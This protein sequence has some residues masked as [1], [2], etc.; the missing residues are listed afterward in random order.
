MALVA[1]GAAGIVASI[2]VGK[3]LGDYATALVLSH[4]PTVAPTAVEHT[5]GGDDALQRIADA[6]ARSVATITTTSID[7]RTS[8]S[9]ITEDDAVG[10][11]VVAAA[12]GWVLTT[13][14]V[15]KR[16]A[17]P[18]TQLEVWVEGTRYAVT[19][20][21]GDELTD[22][23]LMKIDASGLTP[24]AFGAS[25]TVQNGSTVYAVQ[26]TRGVTTT[27]VARVR[28]GADAVAL[29]AEAFA[30][31][32]SLAFT[33]T[34]SS[35]VFSSSGD[36]LALTETT[37]TLPLHTGDAFVRSVLHDGTE[38]IAGLGARVVDLSLPLNIDATLSQGK[39]DGALVMSFARTSPAQT[40]GVEV[41]DIITAVDD[42]RIDEAT[43]LAEVLRGYVPGDV[44]TLTLVRDGASQRIDVHFDDYMSLVY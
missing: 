42:V 7:A 15:V 14:D 10:Y 3:S 4:I 24:A 27:S 28:A 5:Q 23:V 26:G 1:G 18:R 9:W 13:N 8:T 19:Q 12:D 11:G 39:H 17:N 35:P 36:V 16:A 40:A 21:V 20:V 29:P 2:A 22:F 33:P 37:T 30:F 31:M 34:V 43:A 38:S 44:A 25:S 6:S 41:G 32:W